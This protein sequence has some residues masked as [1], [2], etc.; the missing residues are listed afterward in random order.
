M[1]LS[2]IIKEVLDF[3]IIKMDDWKKTEIV[4]NELKAETIAALQ[5]YKYFAP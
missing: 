4:Y 3:Y 1:D 5:F 2:Q